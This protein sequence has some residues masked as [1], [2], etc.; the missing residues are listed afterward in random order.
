M[1]L[2]QKPTEDGFLKLKV[3]RKCRPAYLPTNFFTTPTRV[4]MQAPAKKCSKYKQ[5]TDCHLLTHS[6][7]LPTFLIHTQIYLQALTKNILCIV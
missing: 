4:Y 6:V 3:K 2:L 5:V 1:G 7:Q